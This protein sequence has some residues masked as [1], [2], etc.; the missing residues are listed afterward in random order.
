M[1]SVKILIDGRVLGHL[2][3][4]PDS[5][6]HSVDTFASTASRRPLNN[7][8]VRTVPSPTRQAGQKDRISE[9]GFGFWVPIHIVPNRAV[10]MLACKA[11]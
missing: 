9:A 2:L 8:T 3:R 11:R 7:K 1:H 10:A 5:S 4:K 6:P